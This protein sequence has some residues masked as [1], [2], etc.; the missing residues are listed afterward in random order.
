MIFPKSCATSEEAKD[1]FTK[2]F[3]ETACKEYVDNGVDRCCKVGCIAN[4]EVNHKG[5]FN[6]VATVGFKGCDAVERAPKKTSLE[7]R[8][9]GY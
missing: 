4:D 5:D 7:P 8:S 9:Q 1:G 6:T 3:S 2:N